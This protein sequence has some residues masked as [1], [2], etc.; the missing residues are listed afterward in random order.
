MNKVQKVVQDYTEEEINNLL[1]VKRTDLDRVGYNEN[2]SRIV[3][4]RR[5]QSETRS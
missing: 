1:E 5:L 2:L 3:I 4:Y